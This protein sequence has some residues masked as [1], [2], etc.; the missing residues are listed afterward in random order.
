MAP[1]CQ[2]ANPGIGLSGHYFELPFIGGELG[3]APVFHVLVHD[4][5]AHHRGFYP[6]MCVKTRERPPRAGFHP[7]RVF[8]V[9]KIAPLTSQ[10]PDSFF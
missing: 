9:L 10:S 6:R 3:S 4:I 7:R 1:L 2:G 5:E 8:H